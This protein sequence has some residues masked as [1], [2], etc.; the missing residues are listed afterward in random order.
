MNKTLKR[1]LIAVAVAVVV[2]LIGDFLVGDYGPGYSN[3]AQVYIA[4]VIAGGCYWIGSK[5]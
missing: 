1:A 4:A 2:F 5:D 3:E